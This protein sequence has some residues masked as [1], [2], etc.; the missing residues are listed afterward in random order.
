MTQM[1]KT[2]TQTLQK[3]K[4]NQKRENIQF[5]LFYTLDGSNTTF[6]L[7]ALQVVVT[8]F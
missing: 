3:K 8:I 6:T 4:N 2:M 5:S 1:M 7:F